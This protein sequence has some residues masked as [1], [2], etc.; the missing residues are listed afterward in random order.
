MPSSLFFPLSQALFYDQTIDFYWKLMIL[1]RNWKELIGKEKLNNN[2]NELTIT[3]R[4]CLLWFSWR[5]EDL[6]SWWWLSWRGWRRGW[7]PRTMRRGKLQQLLGGQGQLSFGIWALAWTRERFLW[8]VFGR[9]AFW[10]KGQL[11]FGIFWFLWGQLFLV[12]ICG[13]SWHRW[14]LERSFWRSFE[15]RVAF[16]GPFG[17]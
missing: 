16:L 15:Q 10:S 5:V 17:Q 13:A 1:K 6:W 7:C 4:I 3:F 9:G 2:Q 8:R 14:W 12:W 11:T